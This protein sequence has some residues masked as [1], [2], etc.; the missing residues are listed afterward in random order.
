[1]A[2]HVVTRY[3]DAE[4]TLRLPDLHQAL[5]DADTVF[6]P[7]TV[8]CLHGEDHTKK[9]RIFSSVFNRR[10]FRHYQN[11]VFPK[12]LKETMDPVIAD[13]RGDMARFAYRV[14]INL[15]A[16]SAGIDRRHTEAD[17][18]RL[19]ALLAKLGHAPTMGQLTDPS[20]RDR[21]LAEL[22]EALEAFRVEFFEPSLARRRALVDRHNRGEIDRADLPQDAIT[23]QLIH[24]PTDADLPYDERM[25]DAAFFIL[26]GA[27]TTA[28]SLMNMVN[29]V[30][31]WFEDH[32]EDRRR[33]LDDPVLMQ[34]FIWENARLHP[35]SP[36][37]K[38]RALCP[39]DLPDGHH[40]AADDY[41][42]LDLTRTNRNT[43]LFGADAEA[44]NPYRDL[45]DT[46]PQHGLSFG[47]GMHVCLGKLLAVGVKLTDDNKDAEETEVGTMALVMRALLRHGIARDPERRAQIDEST[48]RRHFATLPFVLDPALAVADAA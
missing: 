19:L 37:T 14:L 38:R 15:T 46:L 13:G 11:H 2:E 26:A 7:R 9:K 22:E 28:N 33:L 42:T 18:D 3:R 6:L 30:L 45:P 41:V 43:D 17:T 23:V 44:F 16:D 4:Q 24:H 35:A 36:I 10:F 32:P 47:G 20:D 1:M 40:T 8:V 29:E 5:Y 34:R 27:F 48:A 12:A 25:K 21:L 31:D 39:M